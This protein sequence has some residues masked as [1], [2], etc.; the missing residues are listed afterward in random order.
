MTN[1]KSNNIAEDSCAHHR[2]EDGDFYTVE[3]NS[4]TFRRIKKS[5]QTNEVILIL[6]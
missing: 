2:E 5:L 4:S 6:T 1:E 3:S